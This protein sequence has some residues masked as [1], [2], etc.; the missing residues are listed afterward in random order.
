METKR[1]DP[2]N[3][4]EVQRLEQKLQGLDE[5][6]RELRLSV[7]SKS[8][9][10]RRLESQLPVIAGPPLGSSGGERHMQSRKIA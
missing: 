3:T 8:T 2:A 7:I 6:V 5:A 9:I 1:A 10:V 4:A